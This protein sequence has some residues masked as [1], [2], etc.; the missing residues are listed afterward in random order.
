MLLWG[1][2]ETADPLRL[3]INPHLRAEILFPLLEKLTLELIVAGGM[4]V[5]PVYDTI[6]NSIRRFSISGADGTHGGRSAE[7]G[8]YRRCCHCCALSATRQ[9]AVR[10]TQSGS[11]TI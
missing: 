1:Q 2:A 11:P 8:K 9:A 6:A 3:I 5:W 10:A 4:S 7:N